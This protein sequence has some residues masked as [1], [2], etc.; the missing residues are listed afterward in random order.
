MTRAIEQ[1]ESE[2]WSRSR[3]SFNEKGGS[4]IEKPGGADALQPSAD[5]DLSRWA[6]EIRSYDCASW[7][8]DK[9]RDTFHDQVMK[10]VEA[11]A[12][13]G[14]V[15]QDLTELLMRSMRKGAAANPA[16]AKKSVLRVQK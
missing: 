5:A 10:P 4:I 8:A 16:P 1:I 7:S 9:F 14:H 15:E 2:I 3:L 6:A 11:K 12:K 13:A